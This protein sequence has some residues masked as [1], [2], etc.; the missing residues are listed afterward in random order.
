MGSEKSTR[1]SSMMDGHI[2]VSPDKSLE[3]LVNLF[4]NLYMISFLQ[5][6]PEFTQFST[7]QPFNRTLEQNK[8][9]SQQP[10]L[11]SLSRHA[12]SATA[13]LSTKNSPVMAG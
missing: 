2:Y 9:L 1:L 6:Y 3:W 8:W 4:Y 7:S 11:L 5:N 13:M 10:L 12:V